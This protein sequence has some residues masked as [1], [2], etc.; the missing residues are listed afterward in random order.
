MILLGVVCFVGLT[1]DS[2]LRAAP[3]QPQ[4]T[5]K[6]TAADLQKLKWIEGSWKGTG[7]GVPT[8]YER[9]RFENTTLLVD[10]LEN[11]KVKDTSRFELKNSEFG[12]TD[13]SNRSVATGFEGTSI[14]FANVGR[15]GSG[16]KWERVSDNQWRAVIFWPATAN[17]AAGERV[18]A[19]DRIGK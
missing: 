11:D 3:S 13:G 19:M 6:L 12:S 15:P 5:H 9:Y 14:T 18:Y 7:G 8:F 16:W 17:R 2:A 4:A 1:S 10:T